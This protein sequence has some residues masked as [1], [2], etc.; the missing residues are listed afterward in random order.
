MR[1]KFWFESLNGRDQLE[2]IHVDGRIIL[3]WILGKYIMGMWIGFIW[4]RI[5]TVD[6]I[7]STR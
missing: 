2:D 6:R 4:L 7:L 3:K 1:T 5:G